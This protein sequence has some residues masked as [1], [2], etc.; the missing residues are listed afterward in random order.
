MFNESIIGPQRPS[1]N[2]VQSQTEVKD[3]PM[4]VQE[5]GR[6]V[7]EQSAIPE[8]TNSE[9]TQIDIRS[10]DMEMRAL[11]SVWTQSCR[12]LNDWSTLTRYAN[13][14][15]VASMELL[16]DAAWHQSE[17]GLARDLVVQMEAA[18]SRS[19]QFSASLLQA[20]AIVA[21]GDLVQR[22][23]LDELGTHLIGSWRQLPS[24]VTPA[25][26]NLVRMAQRVQEVTEANQINKVANDKMVRYPPGAHLPLPTPS[27]QFPAL[28]TH[29]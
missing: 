28:L 1:N 21:S 12:E 11:E 16:S 29:R 18:G 15:D 17:W 19:L 10:L 6:P 24:L 14:N 23:K 7:E 27:K 20:K 8:P 13:C 25:H 9:H 26:M 5:E 4:D 22:I 3:E 2:V